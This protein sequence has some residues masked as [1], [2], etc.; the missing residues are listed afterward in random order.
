MNTKI[1]KLENIYLG[2]MFSGK[3]STL[4]RYL[5]INADIG[6][7]VLYINT[8]LDTRNGDGKDYS[9]HNS[10][11]HI[12]SKITT[13]KIEK[14]ENINV[15][16]YQVIGI[17]EFQFYKDQNPSE[18]VRKWIFSGKRISVSGLDG[19]FNIRPFGDI[20]NLVPLCEAGGL[21]KMKEGLCVDCLKQGNF[22]TGGFTKKISE[23][24]ELIDIGG[25]DKYKIVCLSCHRS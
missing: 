16:K 14:L 2:P 20:L 1:G 4:I 18:V 12:S 23:G 19:D 22:V 24:D 3:T 17:D 6:F 15:E 13:I 8:S 7:K 9:T 21:H 5:T 10:S 11:G 25:I